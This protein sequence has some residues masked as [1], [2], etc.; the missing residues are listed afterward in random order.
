M[1]ELLL[2]HR[3]KI[4]HRNKAGC[5]PLML[6]ARLGMCECTTPHCSV[7]LYILP[8]KGTRDRWPLKTGGLY[9]EVLHCSGTDSVGGPIMVT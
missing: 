6:A 8:T 9:T 7:N 5:T 1:V 3:S 4:E 2:E